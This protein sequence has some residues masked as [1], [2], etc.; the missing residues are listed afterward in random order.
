MKF[1]YAIFCVALETVQKVVGEQVVVLEPRSFGVGPAQ[2]EIACFDL[3]EDALTTPVSGER[4]RQS[5]TDLLGDAGRQQE[6]E[7]IRLQ[8]VQ[9]VGCQ[10]LAYC[11]MPP[12]QILDQRGG[13]GIVP[14]R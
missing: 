1:R 9:D 4:G 6:I 3:F 2:K 7:E 12:G 11:F 13:V 5:A 10:V 8:A 14:K